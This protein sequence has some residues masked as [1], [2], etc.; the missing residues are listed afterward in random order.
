MQEISQVVHLALQRKFAEFKV[1]IFSCE[2]PLKILILE[3]KVQ[4]R[5]Q[6]IN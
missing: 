2:R 5:M 1:V 3:S 4:E 6:E